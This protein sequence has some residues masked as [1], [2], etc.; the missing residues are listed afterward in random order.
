VSTSTLRTL[1]IELADTDPVRDYL[2][3]R[4]AEVTA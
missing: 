3:R 4:L 2:I 1:A